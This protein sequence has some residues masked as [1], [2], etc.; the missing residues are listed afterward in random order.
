MGLRGIHKKGA[1]N[2]TI[3]CKDAGGGT[4]GSTGASDPATATANG[5]KPGTYTRTVAIDP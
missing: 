1:T 5:V 2:S 3:T 4:V